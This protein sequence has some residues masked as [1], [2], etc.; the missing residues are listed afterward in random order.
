LYQSKEKNSR[1]REITMQQSSRTILVTA[2]QKQ[3]S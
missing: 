3:L 2:M 1:Y